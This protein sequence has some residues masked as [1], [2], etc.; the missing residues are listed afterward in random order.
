MN[1]LT[2]TRL[3]KLTAYYTLDF[4]C[5]AYDYDCAGNII[6]YDDYAENDDAVNGR[7]DEGYYDDDVKKTPIDEGECRKKKK[8]K[9]EDLLGR[10]NRSEDGAP[11]TFSFYNLGASLSKF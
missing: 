9:Q 11:S 2:F 7:R 10:K 4:P 8:S 5:P 1:G 6:A 3:S